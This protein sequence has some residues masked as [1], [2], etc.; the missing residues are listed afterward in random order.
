MI[1]ILE[2]DNS[3]EDLNCVEEAKPFTYNFNV[4]NGYKDKDSVTMCLEKLQ[5]MIVTEEKANEQ[6]N[7]YA[8]IDELLQTVKESPEYYYKNNT[9]YDHK[10]KLE[11]RIQEEKPLKKMEQLLLE[12]LQE[13]FDTVN[14]LCNEDNAEEMLVGKDID[15][16]QEDNYSY[17]FD[18]SKTYHQD[19]LLNY[20]T[21]PYFN[22]N[23]N[24]NFDEISNYYN[25]L[26]EISQYNYTE[27]KSQIDYSMKLFEDIVNSPCPKSLIDN[28]YI[29]ENRSNS[30]KSNLLLDEI[31]P[32]KSRKSGSRL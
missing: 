3:F 18:Y 16:P 11:E 23:N 13:R 28:S 9:D 8:G 31:K 27:E 7:T 24:T 5:K 15:N 14:Y 22:N 10:E 21:I 19:S 32:E 20:N 4:G 2:I 30:D 12:N 6:R 25:M 1:E 17:A 26:D 29:I